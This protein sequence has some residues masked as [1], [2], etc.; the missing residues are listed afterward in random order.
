MGKPVNRTL[1][2]TFNKR[3]VENL[4]EASL[5]LNRNSRQHQTYIKLLILHVPV[6]NF[7]RISFTLFCSEN[8]N[9][10]L[11]KVLGNVR[12]MKWNHAVLIY[13]NDSVGIAS[14]FNWYDWRHE[15]RALKVKILHFEF[16]FQVAS[17]TFS[18]SKNMK[19]MSLACVLRFQ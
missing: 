17:P 9:L 6:I 1:K 12:I 7:D 15:K 11:K 4:T 5:N 13:N 8:I 18:L 19:S 10:R 3:N 16:L 2:Y 14:F